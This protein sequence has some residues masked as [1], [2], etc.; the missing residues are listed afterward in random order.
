MSTRFTALEI[1]SG[2]AFL[3]QDTDKNWKCLFD[4]GGSK[5]KIVT[6]L[7]KKKKIRDIDL[8]ICSHND[9]DHANGFLGLLSPNSGIKIKEI[10]L[11]STTASIVDYLSSNK[12]SISEIA[13]L[14]GTFDESSL[15][16]LNPQALF[17]DNCKSLSDK[18]LK[19][20]FSDLAERISFEKK[21]L[22][23]YKS[24]SHYARYLAKLIT[25]HKAHEVF[26]HK[27]KEISR[28][29]RYYKYK[30]LYQYV[31][32][33]S[34]YMIANYIAPKLYR[35]DYYTSQ[36]DTRIINHLVYQET[37]E[38]VS[39]L[40]DN[41]VNLCGLENNVK[42]DKDFFEELDITIFEESYKCLQ[43]I[44]GL[45]ALIDG[46]APEFGL[47]LENQILI[48][49]DR[50]IEIAN[51]A[52]K[53][54]CKIKWFEP[55]D[56]CTHYS[57]PRSNFTAL[58]STLKRQVNSIKDQQ[59]LAFAL[60]LTEVNKYSLVFEYYDKKTPIIRFSADSDYE[61][62][63]LPYNSSIII[64]APHHGSEANANVYGA[65]DPHHNKDNIIWVR[66][67][68]LNK[69][70]GRPCDEFK[71]RSNKYCLACKHR[72]SNKKR[73][74]CFEYKNNRWNP[75]PDVEQCQC[76]PL[77]IGSSSLITSKKKQ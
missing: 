21:I 30:K 23:S 57:I 18:E 28:S 42:H 55:T 8:A 19:T 2:D 31:I 62:G 36:K 49:I 54:K 10:W 71:L 60:Y 41:I 5:S 74:V 14:Y 68:A 72:K 66:S 65:F 63:S 12:I 48:S 52:Y 37:Y 59:S 20:I 47:G 40:V 77:K 64:T 73:E 58:N 29:Y 45:V 70:Q 15:E 43:H 11:P 26:Q 7:K 76:K 50:I 56:G 27:S 38:I 46:H 13:H 35:Y 67:D 9:K 44:D 53:H 51:L 1:G 32:Y 6:L 3:L 24:N 61:C 16:N 34:A 22:A 75:D 69:T 4:A 25:E 39:D 17:S 33:K